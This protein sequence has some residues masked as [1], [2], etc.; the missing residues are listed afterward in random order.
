MHLDDSFRNQYTYFTFL[1]SLFTTLLIA[2]VLLPYKIVNLFGFDE[3]G[4][5]FIFPLTYLLGGAIAESYGKRM[6]LRMVYSSII[7]LL[8]FNIIIAIIVRIPSAP[9]A[10]N[11]EIFL[12]A[13]GHSIRLSIGC[14]VGLVCSDLTNIYRITKLKI[15]FKGKYFIQRCLWSTAISEAIFNVLT[16]L[17]TYFNIL[18]IHEIFKIA[19]YSWILKMVY[20]LIMILPLLMLMRFLKKHEKTDGYDEK[21]DTL[22]FN[23][24]LIFTKFLN[25][26]RMS[27]GKTSSSY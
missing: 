27:K 8:V 17:I 3:P 21:N 4:G 1:S 23:P 15:L 5:I 14:L 25:A 24:K 13:F 11:Q 16:Y 18:S 2:S 12:Q 9:S 10:K 22:Q 26:A 20:S 7:C 6:A 19:I